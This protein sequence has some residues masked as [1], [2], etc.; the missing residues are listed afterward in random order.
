MTTNKLNISTIYGRAGTGKT[1]YMSSLIV[2]TFNLK[3]S[4]VVLT[5]T[6]SALNTIYSACVKLNPFIL[7]SNFRT[8]Y[9]YFRIDYTTNVLLGPITIL[10]SY[11]YID[12]FSLIDKELFRSIINNLK[13]Q[14]SSHKFNGESLNIFI[15]GDILQLPSIVTDKQ[16]IS[17]NKLRKIENLLNKHKPQRRI[18]PRINVIEHYY[19]SIFGMNC[20]QKREKHELPHN[21]R[22]NDII[23]QT[24]NAIY[25]EDRTFKYKFVEIDDIVTKI[26]KEGY[27]FLCSKYAIMQRVYDKIAKYWRVFGVGVSDNTTNDIIKDDNINNPTTESDVNN[28]T[29]NNSIKSD[30]NDN[31]KNNTSDDNINNTSQNDNP[32]NDNSTDSLTDEIVN[33]LSNSSLDSF[34][35]KPTS[36]SS[37]PDPIHDFSNDIIEIMQSCPSIKGL[38]HLYL[39]SGMQIITTETSTKK[40]N[41]GDPLYINGETLTFTGNIE[42]DMLRCINENGEIIYIP[43]SIFKAKDQAIP[44]EYYPINPAFMYSIHKSQGKSIDKVI[45]CID[46]LFDMSMLYT[47]IT[48][49]RKDVLFYTIEQNK[50]DIL[51]KNAYIND[52]KQL[53]LLLKNMVK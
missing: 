10:P 21:Y 41:S 39:Y 6:H 32:K 7:K 27:V 36:P 28:D 50:I 40:N 51:F 53:N 3:R 17:I 26:C 42:D 44:Q 38:K 2:K 16:Y 1:T 37:I 25:S 11:I 35:L 45:V 31:H 24:L 19:L 23:I 20:I 5:S 29:L 30:V 46:E 15:S 9:S 13:Y 48:R 8:I 22:S 33:N 4:F 49:A 43:K 47:A 18:I 52:M 14:I 12:E 34:Q